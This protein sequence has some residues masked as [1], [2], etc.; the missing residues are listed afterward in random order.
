MCEGWPLLP[1][2][3]YSSNIRHRMYQTIGTEHTVTLVNPKMDLFSGTW[4]LDNLCHQ[5][6]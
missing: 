2:H 4:Y 6:L 5:H 3:D 1:V